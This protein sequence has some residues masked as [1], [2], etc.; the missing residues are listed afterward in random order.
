MPKSREISEMVD[1]LLAGDR[2]AAAKLM[3]IVENEE[4]TAKSITKKLKPHI[5]R[6]NNIGITGP[7]GAG[8][9]TI[10]DAIVNE[11]RNRKQKV[12]IV[13]VDPSS[14]FTGGA[15]LGDRIRQTS[16]IGDEK[17]F[18]R[19]IS[20]RGCLG[21]LSRCANDVASILD[22]YG[23]NVILIETTGAGQSDINVAKLDN[24]GEALYDIIKMMNIALGKDAGHFFIKE[25]RNSI[26]EA[27]YSTIDDMGLDLGIM[28]LEH[29]IDELEKK[30]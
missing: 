21:G 24:V 7:L 12:G 6:G 4:T 23:S 11:Y 5:G 22:A 8:K 20:T 10:I 30:L 26:G 29:E 13:A 17:V 19:S 9:S 3:T 14:E 2:K 25:L 28:Q 27:Y 16:S 15:L 1:Q 18:F